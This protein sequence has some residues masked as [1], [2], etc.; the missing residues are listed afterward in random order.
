M[1]NEIKEMLLLIPNFLRDS[2]GGPP[3][4]TT[5]LFILFAIGSMIIVWYLW[6]EDE[7]EK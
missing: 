4:L 2:Y 5:I 3:D 7:N 1:I 6:K